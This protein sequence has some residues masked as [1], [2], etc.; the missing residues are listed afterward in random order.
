MI[1]FLA[2]IA[3]LI[4]GG[5]CYGKFCEKLI[6]PDDNR[7][8]PAESMA[9]GVDYVPL[10]KWKNCL[11]Q[12]LNIAGTGPILGPIQGI[13][14]GPIAFVT[15]PIGCIL[16]GAI[17]DYMT[18]MISVRNKGNQMP[19][20]VRKYMGKGLS[21]AYTIFIGLM[22]LLVAAVFVYT[23]GDL[24]ADRIT[25]SSG[26][27][28]VWLWVIYGLIFLYYLIATIF[29][30]DKIIGKVYPL[31]GAILLISAV[32]VA[33]GIFI[34]GYPL[35]EIWNS[36]SLFNSHPLGQRFFPVF[37]VTVSCGIV[38]GFHTTQTTLITRTVTKE[39][40]GRAVF[41]NMMIL[42]GVIAMI[43]A[44]AA[45]GVYNMGMADATTQAVQVLNIICGDF[46]GPLGGT[47]AMLGVVVL[48]I[49]SG[50]TALRSARLAIGET[51]HIPQQ[52][53]F[54]R[55]LLSLVI[56]AAVMGLL[57]FSKS[58]ANGFNLLWRY[59]GFCNQLTAFLAF[60]LFTI[61]L[62][63]HHQTYLP[64]LIPGAFYLAV[65]VDYIL[66]APIGFGLGALAGDIAGIA[67]VLVYVPFMVLHRFHGQETTLA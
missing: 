17:H 15:I 24:L 11:I 2:G 28:N 33:L 32:G 39:K 52:K 53:A 5:F 6:R 45:M 9:D 1:T 59:F 66:T 30:I 58:N 56:S 7:P 29:P 64:T 48:A 65:V 23:P 40:H 36:G 3:V 55:I 61:W 63:R 44:A 41:Y 38:S 37:F 35:T 19:E 34:K 26:A 14:F 60:T 51:L 13:L 18:G 22:L 67:A 12:L 49:T 54:Q 21:K 43:W 25:G 42:E 31:F 62:K 8:T 47:V 20:L 4:I 50:D 46:L 10:P 57:I 16:G 27:D